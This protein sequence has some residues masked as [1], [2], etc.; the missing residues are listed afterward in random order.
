[1]RRGSLQIE[2]HCQSKRGSICAYSG[3]AM[4]EATP[5]GEH[6]ETRVAMIKS[7][8]ETFTNGH[9]ENQEVSAGDCVCTSS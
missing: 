1:M 5:M 2:R 8:N 3:G 4:C 9:G 6:C 7:N